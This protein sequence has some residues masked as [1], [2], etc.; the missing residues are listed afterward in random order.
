MNSW[1]TVFALDYPVLNS[2]KIENELEAILDSMK[3]GSPLTDTDR[4]SHNN[5]V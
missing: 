2:E 4:I 5:C 3:V 1:L